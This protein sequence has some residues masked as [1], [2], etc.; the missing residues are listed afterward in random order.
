MYKE[1]KNSLNLLILKHAKLAEIEFLI[2]IS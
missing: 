2:F 1:L